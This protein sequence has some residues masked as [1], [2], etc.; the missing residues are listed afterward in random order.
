MVQY[1]QVGASA[2]SGSSNSESAEVTGKN[3][4]SLRVT[5]RASVCRHLSL[6]EDSPKGGN[7]LLGNNTADW[8]PTVADYRLWRTIRIRR[9]HPIPDLLDANLKDQ[10]NNLRPLVDSEPLNELRPDV[11]LEPHALIFRLPGRLSCW[12]GSHDKT[13][14]YIESPITLDLTRSLSVSGWYRSGG[15]NHWKTI[16]SIE[17][18]ATKNSILWVGTQGGKPGLV[19][20]ISTKEDT[21][22]GSRKLA[23]QIPHA[24]EVWQHFAFVMRVGAKNTLDDLFILY[25]DGFQDHII[26]VGPGLLNVKDVSSV[27]CFGECVSLICII[28]ASALHWEE[29]SA[30]HQMGLLGWCVLVLLGTRYL[31]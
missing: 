3:T 1:V 22:D 4:V 19:A 20:K 11:D 16:F 29:T 28:T 21:E 8:I 10:I 5:V 27:P 12:W 9:V 26:P 14:S 25:I 2:G 13:T 6:T 23:A 17:S 31:I 30:R 24:A 15:A 7:T 18:P